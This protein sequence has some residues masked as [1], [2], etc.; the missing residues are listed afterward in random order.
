M[1]LEFIY[2]RR[3]IR[4]YKPDSIS[5]EIIVELLKAAMAAPSGMNRQPWEFIIVTDASMRAKLADAHPY[6]Q[7]AKEAPLVIVVLGKKNEKWHIQDCAAATENILIA[8]ANLGLG[9]VWCGMDDV[10]QAP[11]RKLLNIPEDYWVFNLIPTGYPDESPRPRTQ[12]DE[13]KIHF[14]SF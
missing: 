2:K 12:Y 1:D 7:M 3:S 11:V 13:K 14:E 8:A 9:T 6:A 10:K 4:K 5:K